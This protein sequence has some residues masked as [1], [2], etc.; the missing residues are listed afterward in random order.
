V[1]IRSRHPGV[2]ATV[3]PLG[4]GQVEVLFDQPQRGVAPGQAAVL[5]RGSRVLGGCWITS[6]SR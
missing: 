1:R 6:G 2:E 5:Y 3:R 4:Q